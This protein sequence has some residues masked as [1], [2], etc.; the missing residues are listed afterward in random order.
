MNWISAHDMGWCHWVAGEYVVVYLRRDC[1][2]AKQ[3][4]A[5]TD[6]RLCACTRAVSARII[7]VLSPRSIRQPP[8]RRELARVRTRPVLP[9][10]FR[11]GSRWCLHRGQSGS[12]RGAESS[13][14]SA[15]ARSRPGSFGADHVGAY[16]A[17]NQ[18]AV[19]APRAR[20]SQHALG[21]ARAVSARI[22]LVRTPRSI[23]QLLRRLGLARV[24]T[25]SVLTGQF[26]ADHVGAYTA[27]NQ[28]AAAEP[29]AC[30]NP[31]P[32]GQFRRG[33]RWWLH[34]SQSRS[35]RGAEGSPES[36]RVRSCAG[37]SARITRRNGALFGV[38]PEKQ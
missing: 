38:Y 1:S 20:S 17:V 6:A 32:P 12:R 35:C 11:R 10:Q 5:V 4:W 30:W 33:S 28:A 9:G 36:G 27:V 8:R 19:V 21:P 24:S 34:C 29:R 16:T 7:L 2:V 13:L 23:R 22:T 25:R 18:A 3:T 26:S 15:R 14:E 31:V 37:S